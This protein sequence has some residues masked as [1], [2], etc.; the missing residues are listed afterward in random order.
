MVHLFLLRQDTSLK[1]C[2]RDVEAPAQTL[3]DSSAS[4]AVPSADDMEDSED[5]EMKINGTDD[6]KL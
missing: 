6:T 3:G 2:T 5:V 4:A 1:Q